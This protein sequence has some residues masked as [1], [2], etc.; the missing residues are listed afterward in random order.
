MFYTTDSTTYVTYVIPT[1]TATTHTGFI[2]ARVK[3]P[4]G[5]VLI[6]D[7]IT[8]V[9]AT[10]SELGTAIFPLTTDVDGVYRVT[11]QHSPNVSL[12]VDATITTLG[13]CSVKKITPDLSVYV[14][15][16]E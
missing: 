6:S 8:V 12:D 5:E 1:G 14:Q 10:E 2:H 11:F 7:S 3:G 16:M 4:K 9:E 13:K 15:G